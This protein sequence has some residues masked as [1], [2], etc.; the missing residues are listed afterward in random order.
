MVIKTPFNASRYIIP[1]ICLIFLS[2][3]LISGCNRKD[4]LNNVRKGQIED[5][6]NISIREPIIV[7]GDEPIDTKEGHS[8]SYSVKLSSIDFKELMEELPLLGFTRVDS[9]TFEYRRFFA[10]ND[11]IFA[12]VE[13]K[14]Q[15]V[16]YAYHDE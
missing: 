15:L 9:N 6:F 3:F 10:D 8:D 2:F 13:V 1:F 14:E 5:L 16:H 11:S 7:M 12:L 4:T